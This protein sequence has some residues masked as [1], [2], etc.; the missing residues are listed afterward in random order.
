MKRKQVNS[1]EELFL[2]VSEGHHDYTLRLNFFINSRKYITK[3]NREGTL[4]ILNLIDDTVDTL[5]AEEIGD[6]SL[7]NIGTAIERGAFYMEEI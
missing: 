2:L 4:E 3:G 5:T 7:T 6:K 1:I